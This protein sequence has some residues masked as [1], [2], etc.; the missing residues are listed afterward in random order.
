M[1]YENIRLESGGIL[2]STFSWEGE[3]VIYTSPYKICMQENL[4][5]IP[6]NNPERSLCNLNYITKYINDLK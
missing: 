2:P 5:F 4:I 3:Q 1:K 6:Q